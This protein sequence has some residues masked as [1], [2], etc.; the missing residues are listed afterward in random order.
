MRVILELTTD[1]FVGGARPAED[2]DLR[3]PSIKG[4]LRFFWRA[5]RGG[6]RVGELR[7]REAKLFGS[8]LGGQGLRLRVVRLAVTS[9]QATYRSG[10]DAVLPYLGYGVVNS[11]GESYRG[12]SPALALVAGSQIELELI[13]PGFPPDDRSLSDLLDALWLWGA[14]GG[15]GSRS[16]RGFGS[17]QIAG[18]SHDARAPWPARCATPEH[19]LQ[20]WSVFL[21]GLP[22]APSSL[23]WTAVGPKTRVLIAR[24]THAHWRIA[25]EAIGR[26]LK[27]Q[28]M[29]YGSASGPDAPIV[30]A[31]LTRFP[32]KAP[33][34]AA[35]GLPHSY[36][37]KSTRRRFSFV[38][39]GRG[40]DRRSSPL[41]FHV[42]RLANGRYVAVATWM[43]AAFLPGDAHV[44]FK[45]DRNGKARPVDPPP[46]TAIVE[47]LD[48]LRERGWMEVPR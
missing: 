29:E 42:T 30:Q 15:L 24:E 8:T 38:P 44:V 48:R 5:C 26:E 28:R 12:K 34:R 21:T 7:E 11:R 18:A 27:T 47:F 31:M 6:L 2:V 40:I 3:P 17:V 9:Y 32:P 43:P 37:F 22:A 4:V 10:V 35:F 33:H 41:F 16:R 14:A 25:L 13:P 20:A 46:E 45:V 36:Y 19:L 39:E 1:G 23:D